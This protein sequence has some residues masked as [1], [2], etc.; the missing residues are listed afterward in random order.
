[1]SSVDDRIVN[2]QFNN[3]Q[4]ESG[5]ATSSKS[6]QGL[7]STIAHT[8]KGGGLD[9]MGKSVDG[10]SGK[11]SAMKVAGIA[12]VAT[13]ASKATSA[14]LNLLKSLT[15]DPLKAGFEEYQTGLNSIQTIVSNTG[16]KV[17]AVNA[18][19]DQLNHYSDQTIYN[20]GEMAKNVGTFTAAGVKLDMAIPAI[21]GIA[22]LAALSGSNSQQAS[23]AMYQLSQAISAGKV[24]LQ[25]WNSVVNAGMGG[26]VFQ[27]ALARTAQ[28]MGTLNEGAV[29]MVG[30]M[31]KLTIA[32]SSFRESISA[33]PGQ[34]PWM[35]SEV[36][37]ETLN[38]IAGGFS[39]AQ[40]MRK[41]YSEQEAKDILE[42]QK[43]AFDAATKIKTLPQLIGVVQE[44]VGSTFAGIFRVA[45]G[46]FDQSKKLWTHVGDV[47]IGPSGF[48]TKIQNGM[49]NFVKQW[50][51]LG[52]RGDVLNIFRV[53]FR[54]LGN[55]FETVSAAFRDVFPPSQT[56]ALFE[57]GRGLKEL[58]HFLTPSKADLED[59]RNIFGGIFAVLH[60]GFTVVKAVV[61]VFK[62]LLEG[63][64]KSDGPGQAKTGIL[65]VLGALGEFLKKVD[66]F[67][68][69]GGNMVKI[70]EK[71]GEAAGGMVRQG[72]DIASGIIDGIVQGFSGSKLQTAVVQIASNL[73]E[74]IKGAL[75]IHSPATELIPVG[76]NI[77]EGIAQGIIDGVSVI[78]DGIGK[79]IKGI[80]KAFD[81]LFSGF[82]AMDWAGLFNAIL[83]GGLLIALKKGVEATTSLKD[84][85][86]SV[87]GVID[88]TGNSLKAWQKSLK[89][90]MILEIAI[91]IGI[92]VASIVVLSKLDPKKVAIAIG[93]IT[94]LLGD[95]A[96]TL[97][98][99]SK[100][101]SDKQMAILATSLLLISTAMINLAAAVAI[102]GSMDVKTLAKGF[103]A[104]ALAL[105]LMTGTMLA[106]SGIQGKLASAGA[107]ILIISIALNILAGA[108]ALLG[109]MDLKTLAK[110]LGAI[111]FGLGFI[112]GALI[113]LTA[114][115]PGV[116]AASAAILVVAG[117]LV[118]LSTA[119]LAFG[120]MDLKTLAVGFGAMAVGLALMVG[121]LLVLSGN[122]VGVVAGAAAMV[123]MAAALNVLV[124]VILVLG[125]AP[126]D[127]VARGLGFVAAALGIFLLAAAGAQLV[128]VGLE[129]L[130]SAILMV[131]AGMALAGIGMSL[132]A[133][134]LAVLAVSGTAG[135]AVIVAGIHAFLALLPEIAVQVAASFVAFLKVI[136][137]ASG[138]IRTQFDK[139][140]K[141][142]LGVIS[143]N[144]P[145][146]VNL[147]VKFISELLKGIQRLIPQIGKLISQLITTGI[148]ILTTAVPKFATAGVKII[149]GIL[150][151]MEQ[152]LPK[153]VE[154]GTDIV[155]K[156]IKGL[157]DAATKITKAA[158]ETILDVLNAID[159]AVQKYTPD[160]AEK[161]KDIAIH[162][163]EGLAE[164]LIGGDAISAITNAAS[165]LKDKA[166]G[167]VRGAF[168]IGSP[169]KTM[170]PLGINIAQ[171][172][173]L[174]IT[175]GQFH[176]MEAVAVMANKVIAE[177][178]AAVLKAQKSASR[179]QNQ[180]YAAQ[181]RADIR[182]REAA[183]AQRYAEQHQKDK[184]AQRRA[185]RL[186][187]EAEKT[188]KAA[189]NA[190]AAADRAAQHVEDIRTFKEADIHGKGDIRDQQA[191]AL[192]DRANQVLAKANAEAERGRQLL[193]T[194]R[195][196]GLVLLHQAR[197]DA[198]EARNLSNRA[199]ADHKQ[200]LNY[201][202]QEVDA[203]IKQIKDDQK[204]ERDA[205]KEEAQ[206]QAADAQGKSDILTER[207]KQHEKEA[208]TARKQSD[209][210]VKQA[211]KLADTNATKA[212]QMLDKADEAAKKA[213]E[214]ADQAKQERDQAQQV[215]NEGSTS[216]TGEAAMP[217]RPSRSILQD[218]AKAVD[219]YT[220]SLQ[221]ASALSAAA[222]ATIQYNQYNQS[223]V[224]LTASEIY[225]QSKNL[226]ALAEIKMGANSS[227]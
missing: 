143:D 107:A 74:W 22:N 162:L 141:N 138:K 197:T 5:V 206:F 10:L 173:A 59:L 20:F 149:L 201:Y 96:G 33:K 166:V 227:I 188:Q 100:I 153:I 179:E 23:T 164:G 68:T 86:G 158:G 124:S 194:N 144:I 114:A 224:A 70:F 97:L 210:L 44:S 115:G 116:F 132:F 77:A 85:L 140:F 217:V 211:K 87:K 221:E 137:N 192:A 184:E 54:N 14:G 183:D 36:L 191:I 219:R 127:V 154:K 47:I 48:L 27:T 181:A 135:M 117:A 190:Q 146:I 207:A 180:A 91:A 142:M 108:I 7:E 145:V 213:Q 133:A 111:G 89:S 8:A 26:K 46:D 32:G 215:L 79:F 90:K 102:F 182:A 105:T 53:G 38:E 71:V 113:A 120:H 62:G 56:N 134:G 61:S 209:R 99:L 198:K 103:G 175:R 223:P 159:D 73:V 222:P 119:V 202:E 106:F 170:I 98:A 139:I 177:G 218:A 16:E 83:T 19:L 131:G 176:A 152:K 130:G 4:F 55:I 199:R 203:R 6:L 150:S 165:D 157:G 122:T 31:D 40:L 82:D 9:T 51:E 63:V 78:I 225:R 25:D 104:M 69:S 94:L 75:G 17:P 148:N 76:F 123:L 84:V 35:T 216:T 109:H 66:E 163:I 64:F 208:K 214:A 205:K 200:A 168:G 185:N 226:L 95:L 110:G 24:G 39:K 193:K 42:L 29:K 147:V 45:M 171:G 28:N 220:R 156:L 128:V 3:K 178:N 15:L 167:A 65:D 195:K 189:D 52:G 187:K 67:V 2:M 129:A 186:Q 112:S 18:A 49:T 34:N 50:K 30:P 161:G 121:A 101:E 196:A 41:G 160:I 126:W 136:A 125:T 88:E 21:K 204:A 58:I 155:V 13:I 60:I 212:M 80:F 1:M 174:G 81:G 93:E 57:F 72:I 151:G 92:L 118:V 37:V 12:A 169:A 172:V 43:T 11:F